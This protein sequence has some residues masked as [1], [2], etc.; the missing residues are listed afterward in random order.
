MPRN[1]AVARNAGNPW[2]SGRCVGVP[3]W[4]VGWY[5]QMQRWGIGDSVRLLARGVHVHIA[6][7][8]AFADVHTR[9]LHVNCTLGNSQPDAARVSPTPVKAARGER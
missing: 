7:T 8:F 5:G 4:P 1:L 6:E 9:T 3:A 2:G